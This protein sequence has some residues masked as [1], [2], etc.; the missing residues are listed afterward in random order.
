M[1]ELYWNFVHISQDHQVFDSLHCIAVHTH[2][3]WLPIVVVA[4]DTVQIS[5]NTYLVF[6]DCLIRLFVPSVYDILYHAWYSHPHIH[7]TTTLTKW[8]TVYL[9]VFLRKLFSLQE[10]ENSGEWEQ[11]ELCMG[12]EHVCTGDLVGIQRVKN[13]L[14]F[15]EDEDGELYMLA[16]AFAS[17]TS[18]QGV[19]YQIMDP[20]RSAHIMQIVCLL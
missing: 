1:Q 10:D 3:R 14:S 19:L 8:F 6:I 20:S 9:T 12:D 5:S 16:T 7:S 2:Y 18:P 4:I 11:R 15:G 13:I 17:P